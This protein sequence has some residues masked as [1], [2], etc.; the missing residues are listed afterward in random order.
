MS[1][2]IVQAYLPSK[3]GDPQVLAG[4]D[5]MR[6]RATLFVPSGCLASARVSLGMTSISWSVPFRAPRS[7]A[8]FFVGSVARAVLL[9]V[10]GFCFMHLCTG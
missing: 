6:M 3:T 2:G 4:W 1:N 10:H 5:E 8:L 9:C 7:V